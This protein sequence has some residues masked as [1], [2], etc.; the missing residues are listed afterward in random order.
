[1]QTY[2]LIKIFRMKYKTKQKTKVVYAYYWTLKYL[3]SNSILEAYSRWKCFFFKFSIAIEITHYSY[4]KP[5]TGDGAT[6]VMLHAKE[7]TEHL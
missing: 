4:D 7:M 5:V 3:Q 1:M 6:A 2:T